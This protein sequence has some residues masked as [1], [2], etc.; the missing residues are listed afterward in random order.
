MNKYKHC[1]T[2]LNQL[3][4]FNIKDLKNKFE[5]YEQELLEMATN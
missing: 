2:Y 1:I 3:L 5:K 4:T